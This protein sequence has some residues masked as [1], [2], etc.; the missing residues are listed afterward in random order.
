MLRRLVCVRAIEDRVLL[1]ALARQLRQARLHGRPI[2]NDETTAEHHEHEEP[3]ESGDSTSR[4]RSTR[5]RSPCVARDQRCDRTTGDSRTTHSQISWPD[6]VRVIVYPP[7][8]ELSAAY[9][10]FVAP[11]RAKCRRLLG[12]TSVAEDATQETFIRLMRADL[13]NADARV[14]LAW[15]YQTCTRIS[16]DMLR[17]RRRNP[18]STVEP[19]PC[20]GD[21]VAAIEAR[22][23]L[24]R[25]GKA[26]PDDELA[27][28][29]LCRVDGLTQPE[30]ALVMNISERTVRR[31]LDRFDARTQET[32]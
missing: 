15:L 14:V 20:G 10:R 1:L 5:A 28:V 18:L 16:I 13:A 3:H 9:R 11:V 22:S 21:P 32:A 29:V 4:A 6:F 8:T 7:V 24:A 26:T 17:E 2:W 23:V 30:A 19:S 31:L 12:E 27:A 25:I